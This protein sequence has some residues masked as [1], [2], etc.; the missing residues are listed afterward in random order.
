MDALK[1]GKKDVEVVGHPSVHGLYVLQFTTGGELPARLEGSYTNKLLAAAQCEHAE[2]FRRHE[3]GES[4][5]D[6]GD[7]SASPEPEKKT[8]R[9]RNKN[10]DSDDNE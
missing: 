7:A 3:A 2:A 9:K 4:S 1:Y 6:T 8:R 5:F 10:K